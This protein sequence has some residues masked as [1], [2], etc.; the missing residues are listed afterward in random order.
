MGFV[1]FYFLRLGVHEHRKVMN[2]CSNYVKDNQSIIFKKA[3]IGS[4][5]GVALSLLTKSQD[6]GSL[7][8]SGAA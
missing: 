1:S 6:Q 4:L 3:D 7:S 8:D 5:P 2:R